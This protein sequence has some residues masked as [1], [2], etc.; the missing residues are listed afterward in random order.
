MKCISL[1]FLNL[2][3][4]QTILLVT[5]VLYIINAVT[6]NAFFKILKF[7]VIFGIV[8]YTMLGYYVGMFHPDG[9]GAICQF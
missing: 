1:L 3:G 8:S 7:L 4:M 9:F 5:L 6:I 2:L